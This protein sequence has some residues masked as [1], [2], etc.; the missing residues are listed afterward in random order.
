MR[1]GIRGYLAIGKR[2]IA[3]FVLLFFPGLFSA[4]PWTTPTSSGVDYSSPA[5]VPGEPYF[6]SNPER[7][8]YSGTVFFGQN[9]GKI[10]RKEGQPQYNLQNLIGFDRIGNAKNSKS[11]FGD[12]GKTGKAVIP[13]DKM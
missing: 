9:D 7:L 12:R 10:T 3:L 11:S 1:R 4:A 2:V 13:V 5:I 8:V 6:E